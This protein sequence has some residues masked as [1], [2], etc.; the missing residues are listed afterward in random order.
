[1]SAGRWWLGIPSGGQLEQ[2]SWTWGNAQWFSGLG[3]WLAV[4]AVVSLSWFCYRHQAVW[5]KR[6]WLLTALRS[7]LLLLLL[8]C[9][10]DP[11]LRGVL[12]SPRPRLVYWLFDNTASMTLVD[13]LTPDDR[14]SLARVAGVGGTEPISRLDYLHGWWRTTG[15]ALLERLNQTSQTRSQ[16]F[17][18]GG[19]SFVPV[20][21]WE[22][23]GSD[24]LAAWAGGGE[25]TPLG[26]AIEY[27]TRRAPGGIPDALVVVSDFAH[28]HGVSPLDVVERGKDSAQRLPQIFTVGMGPVRAVDLEVA[29]V[30]PTRL[31]RAERAQVE[32]VVTQHG[33]D[34]RTADLVLRFGQLNG[35]G[36]EVARRTIRLAQQQEFVRLEFTPPAAGYQQLEVEVK[37][38]ADESTPANNSARQT[39]TVVDDFLRVGF[40][41]YEPTWEWR[42]VKEVFHRDPLVGMRG[43]RT[44]LQSSAARVRESNPLF[45]PGLVRPRNEFFAT[46]VF[47]MADM[48]QSAV[49]RRFGELVTEFVRD[50]AGGLIVLAGPRFGPHALADSPI[51]DMMPV[52][53]APDVKRLDTEPFTW[54]L[55]AEGERTSFLRLGDTGTDPQSVWASVEGMNWYFP[56]QRVDPLATVLAVHP[57]HRCPDGQ[58]QPLVVMKRFGRGQVVYIA[59]DELWRLRREH[60]EKYYRQFWS[61]LLNHLALGHPLGE[62][63]RFQLIASPLEAG[64]DEPVTLSLEAYN[65]EYHPWTVRGGETPDLKLLVKPLTGNQSAESM[66]VE[67]RPWTTLAPGRFEAQVQPPGPGVYRAEVID[68]EQ[69]VVATADWRVVDQSPELRDPARNRELQQKLAELTD[70]KSYELFDVDQLT[71]DLKSEPAT[72]RLP[73]QRS[74][75]QTPLA[76]VMLVGLL[77]TEWF[78]RLRWQLR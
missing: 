51:G 67:P 17:L 62:S 57:Q 26:E 37:P 28:N 7:L 56:V 59:N 11:Q 71:D 12:Q 39:V 38:L 33:L 31:R 45:L 25:L 48:P 32:V 64:V 70:G 52:S 35:V 69:R 42:F 4:L 63:K 29:L 23:H 46:D 24:D 72:Q 34:G 5:G 20:V 78:L 75:W 61:Q 13:N 1:M 15:R 9:L 30:P 74:L 65:P 49:S 76:F 55:T 41:S 3:W 8:V 2:F 66:A 44:F 40:V 58:H 68:A 60:G 36:N 50:F 6:R 21:P 54:Q 27:L 73:W 19:R 43:F 18:L 10:L 47:V 14:T 77:A 16:Q 53:F 22:T